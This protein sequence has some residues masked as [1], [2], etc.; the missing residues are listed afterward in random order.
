MTS[1]RVLHAALHL[2]DHQLRD[3]DGRLCGKVDDL[4]LT[5]S[6]DTGTV[7]VTAILSGPGRLLYRLGR[8]RLGGWLQ[9]TAVAAEVPSDP[10]EGRIPMDQIASFGPIV[11]LTVP[12]DQLASDAGEHWARDHV[13]AH[14]PGG[15]HHAAE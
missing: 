3:R 12:A 6:A 2:L 8:R 10:G 1:G 7:Y 4:E 15:R 13:I 5:R 11:Q 9:Q 14:I